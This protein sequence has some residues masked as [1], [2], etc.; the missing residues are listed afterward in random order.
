[1][2]ESFFKALP[3][4]SSIF[5]ELYYAVINAQ[6]TD[7]VPYYNFHA[8]PVSDEI[9]LRDPVLSQLRKKRDFIA[10]VVALPP[11]TCYSWH[12]DTDRSAAI[13]MLL[14]DNGCS[15]CLFAPQEFDVVT[16]FV[17]LRYAPA[18]YYAF[19]TKALH[20]V[21]NFNE[22]RFLF[23]LEFIGKDSWLTYGE[24]CLDLEGLDYG[25]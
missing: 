25:C 16:P 9:V 17:E 10:G 22:P 4:K 23:S 15:R 11:D 20:T 2:T 21:L 12:V 24:L 5:A 6:P 13:N 3:Q 18:T 14:Y 8:M 7:W 19:N 1:M